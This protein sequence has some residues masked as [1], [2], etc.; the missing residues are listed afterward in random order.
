MKTP[1]LYT[2]KI[3]V[4]LLQ[5][6]SI[7]KISIK[8]LCEHANISR[9]TL[10]YHYDS[11]IDVFL[12]WLR[13]SV[14]EAISAYDTRPK[15][16]E[17]FKQFLI[18]CKE[19]QNVILH[20]YNSSH[21]QEF[22]LAIYRIG[23]DLVLRDIQ[24]I[25]IELGKPLIRRDEDFM[26]RFYMYIFVGLMMDYFDDGM[27]YDIEFIISRCDIMMKNNIK[28]KILEFNNCYNEQ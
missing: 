21:K 19:N 10:Y 5:E 18:F 22:V 26:A 28:Q 12:S 14:N 13:S 25:S 9:Q 8:L 6:R 16:D 24:D 27:N 15:W 2:E 17:G 11:L 20:A 23:R 4:E 1:D 7:D 3:L